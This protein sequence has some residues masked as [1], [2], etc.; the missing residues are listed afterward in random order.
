LVREDRFRGPRDEEVSMPTA[1]KLDMKRDLKPLY[2]PPI[3][4]VLVQVPE[5][6]YLMVDGV[7]PERAAGPGADPQ[8]REAIGALY[9]VTYTLKFASKAVGRDFV[10]MP[11]E[12][13]FWAEGSE[14]APPEESGPMR[15]T[16]MILEPPWVTQE[17]VGEAAGALA[18][19]RKLAQVPTLRL[20]TLTEGQ[21]AQVLHLGPYAQERPT[22]E[23]LHDFIAERGLEPREKHHEIY[24]SDPNRTAPERLK[25]VI[26]QPVRRASR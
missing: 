13:L 15:W 3:Y 18:D 25:T 2:A 4:P 9:G 10:V 6:T 12:G 21:V 1:T 17:R 24:L 20:A 23:R 16:M 26:R 19:K 8:F 14:D 22:I 5:L 7:I 11:L